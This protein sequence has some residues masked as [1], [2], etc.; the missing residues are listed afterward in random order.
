MNRFVVIVD[1]QGRHIG[2]MRVFGVFRSFRAADRA[3][4]SVPVVVEGVRSNAYVIP[5]EGRDELP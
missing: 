1:G 4:A 2:P 5:I 3:A